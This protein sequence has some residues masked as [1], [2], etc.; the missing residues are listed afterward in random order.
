MSKRIGS[1]GLLEDDD[2][3]L[4]DGDGDAS[5]N[6]DKEGG[7]VPK[8]P[9]PQKLVPKRI[10]KSLSPAEIRDVVLMLAAEGCKTIV[11]LAQCPEL[12][13]VARKS[14]SNAVVSLRGHGKLV[15]VAFNQ[16]KLAQGG[17]RPTSSAQK[18]RPRG[19]AVVADGVGVV[20]SAVKPKPVR[21]GD[22]LVGLEHLITKR[23][24][25][26]AGLEQALAILRGESWGW[27][28]GPT[29][30]AGAPRTR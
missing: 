19:K 29:L 8:K 21:P 22:V 3:D 17:K 20:V 6:D 11:Q 27:S 2:E 7:D 4:D 25:E 18:K 1:L 28:G 5:G 23:R 10:T 30:L 13:G 12:A 9:A 14:I 24:A 16:F 26:I 15:R